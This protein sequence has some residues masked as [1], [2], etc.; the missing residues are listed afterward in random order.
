[1]AGAYSP[2]MEPRA[3]SLVVPSAPIDL[4][5][6][7]GPLRRGLRD[8]TTRFARDGSVWRATRTPDG[9]GTERLL[10]QGAAIRVEAWGPGAEWLVAHAEELV[11]AADD[12][13]RFVPLHPLL[14]DLH[15]R[16]A[17]LRIPRSRA[18]L[19]ALV[20]AICEQKVTGT[21][22]ST[23]IAGLVRRH[24][25]PAP[26]PWEPG[27]A[28]LR[29]PPAAATLAGLPSYSL[30]EL[31]LERRR[32]ETI[33]RV[34]SLAD[35]LEECSDLSF[36][37]ARARLTAL[38]GVG[39]WTAAEVAVRALGD[40]DAVSVGDFHLPSLVAWALA[41]EPRADDARMLELLEPYRGQRARAIRL[42]EAAGIVAPRFGPRMA[43][44]SVA[45]Y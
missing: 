32:A 27:R 3:A 30:H 43:T 11:G 36:D 15:R 42:I 14:R 21:E 35:R 1:M 13:T 41:R 25:E 2:A 40:P 6:T 24:G 29:V 31:G 34:A 45:G 38:P 5:L 8:A 4:R 23:A 16:F 7:L 10:A 19:E 26:G 37:E 39:A 33:R 28:P 17:G 44:R 12:P 20:P 22:A 18:V 9:P